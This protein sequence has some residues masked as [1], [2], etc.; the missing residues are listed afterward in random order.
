MSCSFFICSFCCC[1]VEAW[2][3]SMDSEEEEEEDLPG[4]AR[5]AALRSSAED[6]VMCR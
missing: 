1:S 4:W 2:A 5:N 3:V 6:M